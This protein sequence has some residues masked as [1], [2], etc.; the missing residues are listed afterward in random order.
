MN[1]QALTALLTAVLSEAADAVSKR[2][3]RDAHVVDAPAP[4]GVDMLRFHVSFSEGGVLTWQVSTKD[5]TGLSDML[6]GGPGNRATTLTEMHLEALSSAFSEMLEGAVAKMLELAQ[7]DIHSSGIDM[8]M[9]PQLVAAP[10]GAQQVSLAIDIDGFGPL[11]VVQQADVALLG[12]LAAYEVQAPATSAQEDHQPSVQSVPMPQMGNR[13]AP[14]AELSRLLGVRLPLTVELGRTQQSIQD[15]MEMGV[16]SII[17]LSKLAGDPLDIKVND[18]VIA[19]GEVVVI[20]EEFGIRV[21]EIV[22]PQD[23]LRGLGE[24]S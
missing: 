8:T 17:E 20:D 9:E 21:T 5:A 22:S 3:T 16:G 18:R 10:E 23:R 14:E 7:A 1:Q 4:E 12:H 11:T 13:Q 6:I 24:R 19:R 15:L 2:L